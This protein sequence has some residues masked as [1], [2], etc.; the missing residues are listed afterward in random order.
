MVTTLADSAFHLMEVDPTTS[1]WTM[2]RTSHAGVSPTMPADTSHVLCQRI[3]WMP[4]LNAVILHRR[5]DENV[6]MY[7]F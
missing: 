5:G 7:R 3:Q 1:P 6:L 4:G 2:R